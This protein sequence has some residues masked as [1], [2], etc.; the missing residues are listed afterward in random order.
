[1]LQGREF[2][3]AGSMLSYFIW[4]FNR[5]NGRAIILGQMPTPARS[6]ARTSQR[7]PLERSRRARGVKTRQ[8]ILG[9]AVSLASMEGLEALTIG[10]LA[11]DLRMSKSGLFAH[12]GSKEELQCCAVEAASQI[13]V[14]QVI[15]PCA[16]MHGV[17]R[18]R[19]LCQ[20]WFRHTELKQFPGGCFFTA[21]SLEFDDRP[22]RVRD[23]I[24]ELM[25]R[26]L[27]HLEATVH[28]AQAAGEVA[29][30]VDAHEVAFEIHSLAMGANWRARLFKDSAAFSL[31]RRA[32]FSR[33][34]QIAVTEKGAREKAQRGTQ[35]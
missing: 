34:D 3:A 1:M 17:R 4:L 14:D 7:R 32:I 16:G 19:A 27:H 18:L 9:K 33:V 15:R 24:V 11:A 31:A 26:W 21:A 12:F 10:R 23:R 6:A 8:A 5:T 22:G 20:N 29:N 35:K 28:E 13:F 2:R 30:D 25:Q